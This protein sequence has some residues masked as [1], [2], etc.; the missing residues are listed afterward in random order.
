MAK[1]PTGGVC[2]GV[3]YICL[4]GPLHHSPLDQYQSAPHFA[5]QQDVP[6]M[7]QTLEK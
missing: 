7:S 3:A 6:L 2:R 4:K 1:S 5:M